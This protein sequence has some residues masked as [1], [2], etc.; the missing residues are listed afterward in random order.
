MLLKYKDQHLVHTAFIWPIPVGW[1][2]EMC[3]FKAKSYISTV[4][5]ILILYVCIQQWILC[6]M[7]K[8]YIAINGM[9]FSIRMFQVIILH[10]YICSVL[11][12]M[13]SSGSIW[14]FQNCCPLMRMVM[15]LHHRTDGGKCTWIYNSVNCALNTFKK[16]E[17]LPD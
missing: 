3:A 6:L 8:S 4:E 17:I 15:M 9:S 1:M 16:K 10:Q 11:S 7:N 12:V 5:F 14:S 13:L 2:R